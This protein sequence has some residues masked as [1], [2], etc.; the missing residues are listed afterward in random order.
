LFPNVIKNLITRKMKRERKKSLVFQM[1]YV[2][3]MRWDRRNTM[4][5][6]LN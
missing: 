2:S 6:K 5:K 4:E 3:T 1:N